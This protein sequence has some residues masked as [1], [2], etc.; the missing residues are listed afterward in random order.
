MGPGGS[1]Q[2]LLAYQVICRVT[3][4]SDPLLHMIPAIATTTDCHWHGH[5]KYQVLLGL[6]TQSLQEVAHVTEVIYNCLAGYSKVSSVNG[7]NQT[8]AAT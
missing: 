1:W 6:D 2:F 5:A 4:S 3:S 8:N 7:I